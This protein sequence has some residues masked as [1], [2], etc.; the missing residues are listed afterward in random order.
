MAVR[1]TA[2]PCVSFP[3]K[4]R[5]LYKVSYYIAVFILFPRDSSLSYPLLSIVSPAP[6]HPHV[7]SPLPSTPF[8]SAS[9][10]LLNIKWKLNAAWR[11]RKLSCNRYFV[12][13]ESRDP[14]HFVNQSLKVFCK[15]EPGLFTYKL[16]LP[17][18]KSL[19]PPIL[20]W[21]PIGIREKG[22]VW[23]NVRTFPEC[24]VLW[25]ICAALPN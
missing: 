22:G 1:G 2:N 25:I 23:G 4:C 6:C 3:G 15:R 21:A 10:P 7:S 18:P 16:C 12:V 14:V 5:T 17:G 8:P 24:F 13:S 9:H 19:S 11:Q 20:K